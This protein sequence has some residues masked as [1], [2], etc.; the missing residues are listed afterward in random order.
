MPFHRSDEQEMI[1]RVVADFAESTVEPAAREVD[2]ERRPPH[3]ALKGM[4]EIGLPGMLADESYGGAGADTVSLCLAVEKLAEACASTAALTGLQNALVVLPIDRL[5]T[6]DQKDRWLERLAT[7]EDRGAFALSEPDAGADVDDLDTRLLEDDDGGLRLDGRKA[8]SLGASIA[9]HLLVAADHEDGQTVAVV[10]A[11]RDGVEV[12]PDEPL[13]GLHGAATAPVYLDDVRVEPGE[14]LGEVGGGLDAFA[15]PLRVSRLAVASIGVGLIEA[16]L[17][18]SLDFADQREQFG[19]PIR[20]FQE[21]QN[22]LARLHRGATTARQLTLAAA[23][24]RDRGDPYAALASEAKWH[25]TETAREETRSAIRLHGG[26]GYRRDANVERYYRDART[27]VVVGG[28]NVMH[29]QR[30]A[31]SL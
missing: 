17:A 4:R 26:T 1:Q 16:A 28:P 3:E 18:D 21:S 12:G 23:D 5:G 10:P 19:Q 13:I 11:D 22:R 8:W 14:V 6:D 20:E 15:D 31:E 29:R 27:L 24:Q 7:G 9:D 25:A 2:R 30:V